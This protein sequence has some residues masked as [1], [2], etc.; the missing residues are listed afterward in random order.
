M[1]P[2]EREGHKH[3]FA[4]MN[5]LDGT[6]SFGDASKVEVKEKENVKF[7]QKNGELGMVKKNYYIPKIRTTFWT[8]VS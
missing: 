5:E 7:L 4:E 2:Y 6:I 3:L 1:I 8:W